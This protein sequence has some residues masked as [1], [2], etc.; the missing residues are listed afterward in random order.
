M[1][2]R[3]I[4][5]IHGPNLDRLG[6]REPLV[7]GTTTWQTLRDSMIAYA[8]SHPRG[9]ELVMTTS[10][11]EGALIE[12]VHEAGDGGALGLLINP[13]GY[14]HSS[15]AL[16]DALACHEALYKIEIHWSQLYRRESFR[17]QMITA[18]A[19]DMVITGAGLRGYR[20]ALDC[21]FFGADFAEG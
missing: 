2:K 8:A 9:C 18:T 15:V 4:A 13:G 3:W 14:A 1:R 17:R 19:V 7:Y 11:H 12:A 10:C 20:S 6:Q 16:R 5:V 21:L